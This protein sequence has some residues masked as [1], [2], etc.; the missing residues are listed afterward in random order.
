M[1]YGGG[2]ALNSVANGL[3]LRNKQHYVFPNPGDAGSS[4]G[5]AALVH[6]NKINYTHSF[7]GYKL[8]M[9]TVDQIKHVVDVLEKGEPVG[10][11]AGKAEFGPRALGNRSLYI[12]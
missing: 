8:S 5:A 9:L 1:V 12:A 7:H 3:I 11:A 4:L 6:R 10:I 2:V